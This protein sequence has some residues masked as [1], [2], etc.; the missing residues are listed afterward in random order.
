MELKDTIDMMLSEDYKERFKAEYHQ[1]KIRYEKLHRMCIKY[2]AATLDF[3]PACSLELLKAQK[4][5]M[6]QY[7]QQMEIRA[8][9]EDIELQEL[10]TCADARAGMQAQH[11]TCGPECGEIRGLNFGEALEEAKR[12]GRVK[13]R[14]WPENCHTFV[15]LIKDIEFTTKA[16]LSS[17]EKGGVTVY[18]QL[19]K[20]VG[21]SV[22]TVWEPTQEDMLAEDW[23]VIY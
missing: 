10:V 1:T 11:V 5:A 22:F 14:A 16:D 8:E 2:E 21:N 9:L 12:G 13:R 4:A 20:C 17:L 23:V 19:A 7:L 15:F 6:G 18:D 3:E